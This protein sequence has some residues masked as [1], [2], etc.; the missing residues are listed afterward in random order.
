MSSNV[1]LV[2]EDVYGIKHRL[3][4]DY[5]LSYHSDGQ[6]TNVETLGSTLTLKVSVEEIDTLLNES[7]YMFKSINT[8]Q[9]N[10]DEKVEE[11]IK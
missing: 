2:L 3:F 7:L 6:F 11:L 8:R 1:V 5:I 9:E 10:F 4:T